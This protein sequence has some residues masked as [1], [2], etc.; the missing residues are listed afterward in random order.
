MLSEK[1]K[2]TQWDSAIHLLEEPKS[3]ILTTLN[4]SEH[5]ELQ[6]FYL[7]WMQ[8]NT[9]TLEGSLAVSFKTKHTLSMRS[10]VYALWYLHKGI[11][12]AC[13]HKNL[14]MNI[15][16]SLIH[17][18][19]TWRQPRQPYSRWRDQQTV[20]YPGNGIWFNTEKKWVKTSQTRH[21]GNLNAY[22]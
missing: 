16:N 11:K 17:N 4:D 1:G 3:R 14:H 5:V 9:A 7:E 12:N 21:G 2:S 8:N 20:V 15:Y 10:S 6:D 19:K 22:C 13:P 18:G